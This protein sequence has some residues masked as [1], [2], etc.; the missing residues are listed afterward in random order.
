[1]RPARRPIQRGVQQ[2]A[3]TT[4]RVGS[5]WRLSLVFMLFMLPCRPALI[6]A[7]EAALDFFENQIRPLLADHCLHCH[8]SEKQ[9]GGLRLDSP[10]ALLKGGDSGPAIVAGQPKQSRLIEAVGYGGEL[11]MP[12][13]DR[14]SD[15]QI[16]ALTHWVRSG[17][18]WPDTTPSIR[19]SRK[20]TAESHW[21]FQPV[22]QP[23]IPQPRHPESM[24]TPVDLFVLARL[25]QAGLVPSPEAD[26][27]TLIRRAYYSL[28]GL[29]PSPED[30]EAFVSD[31]NPQA[32]EHLI[33]RL[34]NSSAYGEQWARHWLDVARY[35]DTKGYVYAREERFWVHAWA[36]RDWVVQALNRDMPYDR[37][38]LLQI[39]ADQVADAAPGDLAAMGFLT[40]GRRFLGVQRDVIDDRIDVVTR[41]T[42]SLTVGCARCHDHKYDPIPTADYYSLYGVFASSRERLVNLNSAGTGHAEFDQ[43]LTTRME[44]LQSALQERRAVTSA[45][46]R[47]RVGDYLQ[48]Q[49]ELQKYPEEGFDQILAATDV[50]PAFVHRWQAWLYEAKRREDSAFIPW[51]A[52]AEIPTEQFAERASAVT[53]EL[54]QNQA[55]SVNPVVRQAFMQPPAS[56]ADVIGRYAAVL[57]EVDARWQ[58]ELQK[59][60]MQGLPEPEQLTDP[61]MEQLRQVLYG[62][63]S[64]CEVPDE[65]IVHTENDFDSG[66]CTDLWKL[67][68]E[69][70]RWIIKSAVDARFAVILR[71]SSHP[72]EA[73]IFK[74]GNPASKGDSVPRRFLTLL[75][76]ADGQPFQHG[77]GRRELAEAIIDPTNP[78]TARV[79]VNRVWAHHFG[80][81][82][83]TTPGDF[84]TRADPP[85]H[86]ELLDWLAHHFVAE[87][88]S[89]KK[90]HRWILLSAT[91]RQSSGGPAEPQQLQHALQTDPANRLLWRMNVRRLSFEELRDSML[92]ASGQLDRRGGGKPVSLFAEPFPK[93]RT[94]YG[95][96]DR[97]FLPGTLRMFDFANPDLHI[98]QRS[99]TTVPQQ[100]L[101]LMNHPLVLERAAGLAQR[102]ADQKDAAAVEQMFEQAF[103]RLPTAEE[104]AEALELL[105]TADSPDAEPIR[106]TVVDWSYGYGSVDETSGRVSKFT[107]L[108][109]FTGTAWQ[110][111]P[112]WP[113]KTLGWVQLT[114]VGGHPGNDSQHASVRRWT[115]PADMTIAIQ[116]K[117]VHEAAPGDGVRARIIS[118]RTGLLQSEKIHQKTASLTVA[119][120]D[121]AAGETIDFVVDIGDVLNSD[122][123]EW[124][125]TI[126]GS[127]SDGED[128]SW[129]SEADFTRTTVHQ[130]SPREQLAQV[131]LCSN[132]FLFVD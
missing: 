124:R 21:A 104:T 92:A 66:T 102:V 57:T 50:L 81:G 116:S 112:Q 86:P 73:R 123:H 30:V 99:E 108:P 25:D 78:L 20:P 6:R 15:A 106:S 27:R 55:R 41:G 85:S 71:D 12:P 31:P 45:R 54:Q 18:V 94:L 80:T 34:L 131:L 109:H 72:V 29:P 36:Y 58:A 5:A 39:A 32:W 11:Q 1:M 119:S 117:L 53:A 42:M 101:F 77:S 82:L 43:G 75:Q 44:K 132:E 13:D 122:Q 2:S 38:L 87:G 70:D 130:L 61:A 67:Q 14:L 37:F 129:N 74:R 121:V 8:G 47:A 105:A 4:V 96:V 88:W 126:S 69:L 24:R 120:L 127:V 125:V 110:G 100:A 3:R 68:A 35:S 60:R 62:P 49:R 83:V 59:A 107:A 76:G 26:R 90:L 56:F 7:D 93:R 113:D 28:T 97:Q 91:F 48:A 9:S 128:R 64:P 19:A 118:S 10:E 111:G 89:L 103:Q 115:A 95:L 40:I 16:A 52:F 51:H 114:A 22:R 23:P 98:P 63:G 65:P 46:V 84:G 17:A 33:E 79:I